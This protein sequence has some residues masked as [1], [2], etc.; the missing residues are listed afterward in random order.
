MPIPRI[1]VLGAT[2]K[3]G[4]R[5]SRRLTDRGVPHR[6]ASR[7]SDP[8]FDWTDRGTWPAALEG[9]HT[10]YATYI[11]DLAAPGA[12]E[13]IRAF[14]E[15]AEAHRVRRVVLLSERREPGATACEDI[16]RGSSMA[17]TIIQGSW[18]MQNFS[19]GG[20]HEGVEAGRVAVPVHG[21]REP[22][23]DLEDLADV[24]VAAL[25]EDGHEGRTYEVT[26]PDLL[27]WPDALERIGQ[28]LG[29]EV[30]FEA[31]TAEAFQATL[32]GAGFPAEDAHFI[33]TLVE[34]ILDGRNE[35][36]GDGVQRAL[37]R[38]PTPFDTFVTRAIA[39]GAWTRREDG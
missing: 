7:R 15:A 14:V 38:A 30:A 29:R 3:T 28:A 11:P 18:F 9:M 22:F 24:A 12:P 19:E 2:G 23:V 6:A 1:L 36:L 37:G 26:G 31:C 10:V 13:D 21:T 35:N 20:F 32:V 8:P 25:L 4:G 33:A 16:L 5:V 27:S 17:W 39:D 34:A